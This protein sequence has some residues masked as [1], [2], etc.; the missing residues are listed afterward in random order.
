MLYCSQCSIVVERLVTR[1]YDQ[2]IAASSQ[3]LVFLWETK[4]LLCKAIY[5][6][7]I[8]LLEI[9]CFVEKDSLILFR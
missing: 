9:N 8:G 2:G 4:V 6:S 3:K 7:G 5:R 1:L